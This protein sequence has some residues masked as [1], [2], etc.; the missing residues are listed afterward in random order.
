MLTLAVFTLA[1]FFAALHG[2]RNSQQQ[3]NDLFD[4]DLVSMTQFIAAI[5][6]VPEQN[7]SGL[8]STSTMD[9][10]VV[11]Q[12]IH[13]GKVIKR[14][15]LAPMDPVVQTAA[16]FKDV[17]FFAQRW[18]SY[19]VNS[20]AYIVVVA[21]PIE[22][23]LNST[24][25]VV[26]ST[27]TPIVFAMPIIAVL[28]FYV[29]RKSLGSL[30]D[31]SQQ[32]TFKN[33]DDLSQVIIKQPP[34]ELQPVVMRLNSLLK[35]LSLAFE[36]ERTLSANTAH[37]LRT[38]VSVLRLTA[39]NMQSSFEKNTLQLSHF[40]ELDA[41]VMR[42]AHV[43][44]QIIALYRYSP[45]HFSEQMREISLDHLL[46]EVIAEHY[47]DI[48]SAQQDI[49]LDAFPV[50]VM[51]E[52]FALS[53]MFENILKNAIKYSGK[54]SQIVV[55]MHRQKNWIEV[56]TEDS[57]HIDAQEIAKLTQTFYRAKNASD[58]EVKGSGLGLSIV[59]YITHIHAGKLSLSQSPLG[60]LAVSVMLKAMQHSTDADLE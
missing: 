32:L 7:N 47:N 46:R 36:R 18:R 58:S 39:H 22:Y 52:P 57:G 55:S 31:L 60:G 25:S 41:N 14:S 28:L 23:R 21:Q 33:S 13:Q 26:L 2:Y 29:I 53:I 40:E 49:S 38:P 9:V 48:Q 44:E 16:G 20:G 12:V 56:L 8:A 59:Q 42:M 45:E 10:A 4:A 6:F 1:T 51:G 34:T 54:G 43:I 30:V 37:E 15:Q 17:S 24:E 19:S 27:V 50:I 5:E 35:R 11:F 3:I